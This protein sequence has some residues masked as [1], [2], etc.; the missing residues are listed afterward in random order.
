MWGIFG[1][2][3]MDVYIF[4]SGYVLTKTGFDFEFVCLL[5]GFKFRSNY[6]FLISCLFYFVAS[7]TA[8]YIYFMTISTSLIAFLVSFF[9]FTPQFVMGKTILFPTNQLRKYSLAKLLL[10]KNLIDQ[11][12]L[13]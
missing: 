7:Q 8:R 3:V 10:F 4:S 6:G 9:I 5:F 1:E 12:L 13:L 11:V 2:V